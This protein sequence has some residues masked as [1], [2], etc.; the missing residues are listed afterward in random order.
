MKFSTKAI[1]MGSEPDKETGAVM[2]P[3]YMSSTFALEAPG[4][5]KGFEYTRAHNPN[6]TSLEK[7]LASL[8]DAKY[9]TV[10][11]SGIGALTALSS[12][13]QSGDNVVVIDGVYGGTYRLFNQVLNRFGIGFSSILPRTGEELKKALLE[14]KPKWLL[15]ES[16]TN[17]LLDVFDIELFAK[18]AKDLGILTIVDNT[19]A[20]PFCQNPLHLGVDVVWHSTTKYIGGHSDVIGGAVMSNDQEMKKQLDFARKTF[21]VNPSPFDCWLVMRGAKTLP[22]RM[23]RHNHNAQ[24]IAEFLEKHPKVKKVYYPGLPS[25]P[26]HQIAKKQMRGYSGVVSAEFHLTLEQTKKL[27]ASFRYICL[28]ESLGGVESLVNHPATMTHASIPKPERDRMG[29]TDGLVRFSIGL[30]DSGD[31]IEDLKT[32]LEIYS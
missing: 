18:V 12:L 2:P 22:L 11:S 9:A 20:S 8:E 23:E 16:P 5:D 25:H 1:H 26:G 30:E 13:L 6:F 10:F 21:G 15:F 7:L 28:A 3:I 32:A 17:P 19:F 14:K 31:L 4:V 29:I 27:I 24:I